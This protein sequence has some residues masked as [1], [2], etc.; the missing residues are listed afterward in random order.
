MADWDP[1]AVDEAGPGA[2]V[3][4]GAGIS[5]SVEDTYELADSAARVVKRDFDKTV[6]M[7]ITKAIT[8]EPWTKPPNPLAD[9]SWHTATCT[10]EDWKHTDVKCEVGTGIV[11]FTLNRPSDSNKL[12]KTITAGLLDAIFNLHRRPDIRVAV[13]TS[14]GAMLC[15]GGDPKGDGDGA[16][17]DV[18]VSP[19]VKAVRDAM[20]EK[21]LKKGA[22]LDGQVNLGRL[23]QTRLWHAW[24]TVPQF[25]ICLANG[26]AM[27]DGIGLLT[28]CDY[29]IAVEG[30]FFSL[31]SV[32]TGLVPA[33]VAPYIIGKVGNGVAKRIFC[34]SENLSAK[35]AVDIG[36]VD[37]VV[38]GVAGGHKAIG[39]MCQQLTK[40]GPRTVQA[41]KELV[42]GVGGQQI[43]HPLMFY[44]SMIS[45]KISCAEEAKQAT[46]AVAAG[47]PMPWESTPIKALHERPRPAWIPSFPTARAERRQAAEASQQEFWVAGARGEPILHRLQRWIAG[48]LAAPAV[49]VA[50]CRSIFVRVCLADPPRS[51]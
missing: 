18:P 1:F 29:T 41:A 17:T 46:A 2:A 3:T 35:K 21:A 19:E 40:C 9:L 10:L 42:L 43:V 20:A 45:A 27:G 34:T 30:A 13:F 28:V 25:T 24:A 33:G 12:N 51:R 48:S 14:E 44:T 4:V 50:S 32:K 26:S 39:A 38:A 22:F 16:F 49:L 7:A 15:A 11:Y 31:A 37:E 8:E 47:K 5:F 23:L 6:T 36:I